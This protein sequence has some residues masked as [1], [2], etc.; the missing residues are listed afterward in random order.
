MRKPVVL[1]T[2]AGGEIGH[3]LVTRLAGVRI[4]D[5]HARR[6]PARRVA[7]AARRA[8]VHR[9]DHRR[10]PARAHARG[11]RGRSRLPPRGAAVDARGVHAGDRA[12]R[13][14][15]GHAQPARVRAA[16]GRIARPPGRLRLSVVD[17]RVR[18]AGPRRRRR[19]PAACAKTSTRIR[20]RCTGATSCTASSSAAT[21]RGTTSS[22]RPTR[23]AARR[24]PLRPVSRADLG[25][26]RAVGRHVRLRAGDDS[27]GGAGA[28]RT[29]ASC[30]PTRRFRSWRCPTAST[31]CSTLAAAPRERLTRTRVQPRRRST[32]RRPRSATSCVAAFPEARDHVQGR[33]EA[34]GDRRL[35]AGRRRRLRGAR[36]TGASTRATISTARSASTS[37]RPSAGA[38]T[39]P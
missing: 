4:A 11:V 2:G 15:R 30:G 10:R 21:T 1:I 29:T 9:I 35:V 36:A 24:F 6:Q 27:R 38:I 28:S 32:R 20:R 37:F 31:R 34:A 13:Q 18:P 16:P 33:R 5:R 3:G 22:C 14:R 19:A 17:R 23:V 25:D 12:S 7:G 39:R 8:R 26:D